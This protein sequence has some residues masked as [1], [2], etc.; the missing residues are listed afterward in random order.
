MIE[1]ISS[2]GFLS[3][4]SF[5]YRNYEN[6]GADFLHRALPEHNTFRT[7]NRIIACDL[8]KKQGFLKKCDLVVENELDP[9]ATH[10]GK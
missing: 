10:F 6:L 8:Q 2:S 9:K 5:R 3:V 4:A 1:V 7:T